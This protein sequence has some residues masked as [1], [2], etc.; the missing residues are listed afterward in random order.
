[1]TT[2]SIRQL[3]PYTVRY[4]RTGDWW[5]NGGQWYK[6][7]TWCVENFN[8]TWEYFDECFMFE[9]DAD[10]TAFVLKWL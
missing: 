2:K 9:K 6:V 3:Y 7:S 1:M 10:R 8:H 5:D 4:R